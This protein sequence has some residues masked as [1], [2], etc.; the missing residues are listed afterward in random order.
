MAIPR[1]VQKEIK[2]M[3]M[4]QIE[5]KIKEGEMILDLGKMAESA[6]KDNPEELKSVQESNSKVQDLVDFLKGEV[7]RRK[8]DDK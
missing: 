4:S 5:G 3:G 7:D 6:A 2:N 8:L 1:H